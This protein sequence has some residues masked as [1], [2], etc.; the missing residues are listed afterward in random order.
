MALYRSCDTGTFWLSC[1]S[2]QVIWTAELRTR[3]DG[4]NVLCANCHKMI[5]RRKQAFFLGELRLA[6][7]GARN[8]NAALSALPS[9]G[10]LTAT[11]ERF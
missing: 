1:S 5:H 6:I 8:T 4:V 10:Y 7:E 9:T 2:S 11:D 3:L